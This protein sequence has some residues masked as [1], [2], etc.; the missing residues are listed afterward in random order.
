MKRVPPDP[1]AGASSRHHQ[2]EIGTPA[3]CVI[4]CA[5]VTERSQP[6][7][8]RLR[9]EAS[10][11]PS[12]KD[13]AFKLPGA[14]SRFQA[15]KPKISCSALRPARKRRRSAG[16]LLLL[17]SYHSSSHALI[18]PRRITSSSAVSTLPDGLGRAA[19]ASAS[20]PP[21]N[22]SNSSTACGLIRASLNERS[23]HTPSTSWG[24]A[25]AGHLPVSIT[26]R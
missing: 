6:S 3:A 4:C 15:L 20:I 22:A 25:T 26:L 10:T 19:A 11:L 24:F 2:F 23:Q 14:A 7:W 1:Y 9:M 13:K 5:A 12:A 8:C 16:A 17:L 18:P 21:A